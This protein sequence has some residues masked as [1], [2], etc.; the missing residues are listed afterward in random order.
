MTPKRPKV[1]L[2]Y[3]GCSKVTPK[4]TQIILNHP[5]SYM[6]I[7]KIKK[8][9][10]PLAQRPFWIKLIADGSRT[11]HGVFSIAFYSPLVSLIRELASA[12]TGGMRGPGPLWGG[13]SEGYCKIL[14]DFAFS[15]FTRHA[16]RKLGSADRSAHSAGLGHVDEINGQPT[17]GL[18][19][20]SYAWLSPSVRLANPL[21]DF[22]HVHS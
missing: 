20:I 15:H 14:Q 19:D 13:V 10:E 22:R 8:F 11:A 21:F 2:I 1:N 7:M 16:P 12:W 5:R 3:R 18:H 4:P 17:V 9:T 6:K